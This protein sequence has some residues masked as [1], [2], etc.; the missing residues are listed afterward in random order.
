MGVIKDVGE[1]AKAAATFSENWNKLKHYLGGGVKAVGEAFGTAG[2]ALDPNSTKITGWTYH[3]GDSKDVQPTHSGPNSYAEDP[4]AWMDDN[5]DIHPVEDEIE[6][7]VPSYDVDELAGE[8]I[9][10][11]WGDGQ[12]RIDNMISAGYSLD[13]YNAV[14]QRVNDAYESGRD[15]RELTDKANEKLRYW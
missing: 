8:F 15:L 6:N 2:R 13:D 4:N 7:T 5:G 1:V 9:L 11:A 14:Q 3:S 12:E 10:G